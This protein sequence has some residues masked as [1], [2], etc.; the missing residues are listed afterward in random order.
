MRPSK[1]RK[2]NIKGEYTVIL[3]TQSIGDITLPDSTKWKNIRI[4]WV[5][6]NKFKEV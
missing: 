3:D 1:R 6:Y 4:K 5:C 2:M